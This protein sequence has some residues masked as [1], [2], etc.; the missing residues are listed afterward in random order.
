MVSF[1]TSHSEP[2]YG[3]HDIIHGRVIVEM[4]LQG[5]CGPIPMILERSVV[6]IYVYCSSAE[7][8]VAQLFTL[9]GKVAPL[10]M[11]SQRFHNHTAILSGIAATKIYAT[12]LDCVFLTQVKFYPNL[13]VSG[14]VYSSRSTTQ[15]RCLRKP[16][17]CVAIYAVVHKVME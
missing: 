3:S 13:V 9:R 2:R 15:K 8:A 5:D 6:V 16:S 7:N 17:A 4:R 12:G 1:V 11:T 10:L 14:S